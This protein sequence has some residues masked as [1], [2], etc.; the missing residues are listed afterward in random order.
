MDIRQILEQ[1]RQD[2]LLQIALETA[3]EQNDALLRVARAAK[4]FFDAWE[5]RREEGIAELRG[6]LEEVEHLL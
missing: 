1:S 3:I 4:L 2:N 5:D 6:A